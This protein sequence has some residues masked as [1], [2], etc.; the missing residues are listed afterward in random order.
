MD[1][2]LMPPMGIYVTPEGGSTVAAS[3][4]PLALRIARQAGFPWT[5]QRVQGVGM[6]ATQAPGI[7]AE[8]MVDYGTPQPVPEG[9]TYR[10][11]KEPGPLGMLRREHTP[12][13]VAE[14]PLRRAGPTAIPLGLGPIYAIGP[15]SGLPS[16]EYGAMAAQLWEQVQAGAWTE[17]DGRKAIQLCCLAL[18]QTHHLTEELLDFLSPFDV[19]EVS[20][21]IGGIM[22]NDPK[23]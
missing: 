2:A 15:K 18:M 10:P 6:V 1:P 19:D 4:S 3:D 11:P 12:G 13:P 20:L 5:W 17:E 8:S 14:T 23:A 21:I 22:G 7:F 16:S 9:G